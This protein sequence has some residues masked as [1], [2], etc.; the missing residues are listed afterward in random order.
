MIY[1]YQNEFLNRIE[2]K[3][4]N[5]EYKIHLQVKEYIKIYITLTLV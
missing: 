3:N 5:Y 4:K 2:R 1:F